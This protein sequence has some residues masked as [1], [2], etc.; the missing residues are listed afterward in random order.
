MPL[1]LAT[2]LTFLLLSVPTTSKPCASGIRASLRRGSVATAHRS[3]K[4]RTFSQVTSRNRNYLSAEERRTTP[5]RLS[6]RSILAVPTTGLSIALGSKL[7]RASDGNEKYYKDYTRKELT[8]FDGTNGKPIFIALKGIIYD[9]SSKAKFYGPGAM[10][11]LFAGR[12]ASR[13]LGK[14]SMDQQDVDDPRMDDFTEKD[15]ESLQKWVQRFE[16]KYPVVGKLKK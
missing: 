3:P 10:Y 16:S 4:V 12:D 6:R 9:V 15:A 13:G 5:F 8:Y 14:M 1:S 11:G 7:A 2:A